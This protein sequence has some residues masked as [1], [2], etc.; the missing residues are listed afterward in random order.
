MVVFIVIQYSVG[1]RIA[2]N[3]SLPGERSESQ[4]NLDYRVRTCL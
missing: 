2:V 4:V 3:L 1:R